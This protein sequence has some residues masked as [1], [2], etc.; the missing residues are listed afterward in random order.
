MSYQDDERMLREY[1]ANTSSYQNKTVI[2]Y[3]L[4][5]AKKRS[6]IIQLIDLV[7]LMGAAS[8]LGDI[9]DNLSQHYYLIASEDRGLIVAVDQTNI[10]PIATLHEWKPEDMQHW[11]K[12]T[13]DG[14]SYRK[15]SQV[16]RSE[17]E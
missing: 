17:R 2:A 6:W 9:G 3:S 15:T 7:I 1:I 12:A 8:D 5:R 13:V 10:T 16:L 11:K 14:Y 4:M